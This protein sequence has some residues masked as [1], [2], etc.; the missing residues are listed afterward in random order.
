MTTKRM[1]KTGKYVLVL[2]A[3]KH[4]LTSR[5]GFQYPQQGMVE[6]PRFRPTH[7]CGEGLHGWLWGFGEPAV[8]PDYAM[9]QSAKWLVI[10]VLKKDVIQLAGKVKFPRGEVVHVGTKASAGRY[11]EDRRPLGSRPGATYYRTEIV[12]RPR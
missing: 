5:N 6:D 1:A 12:Q 10:K 2:R 7:Y 8:S 11:V 3:C 4:D 9:Y